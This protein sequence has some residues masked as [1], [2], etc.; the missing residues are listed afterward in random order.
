LYSFGLVFLVAMTLATVLFRVA[1]NRVMNAT[2][3]PFQAAGT[4][5]ETQKLYLQSRLG[6]SEL[7]FNIARRGQSS[8]LTRLSSPAHCCWRRSTAPFF[9]RS[10]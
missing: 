8:T 7:L 6:T 10:A 2:D 1:Q 9:S 3:S 4:L 5:T